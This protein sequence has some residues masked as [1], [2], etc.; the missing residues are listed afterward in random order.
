MIT[1]FLACTIKIKFF[2]ELMETKKIYIY[3]N[4]LLTKNKYKKTLLWYNNNLRKKWSWT[5]DHYRYYSYT[6][7]GSFYWTGGLRSTFFI[8]IISPWYR[9]HISIKLET[10]HVKSYQMFCRKRI[11]MLTSLKV[12]SLARTCVF[13]RLELIGKWG[14]NEILSSWNAKIKYIN[15]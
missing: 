12:S 13:Y 11:S 4:I 7:S 5:Y 14:P 3:L 9:D 10:K 8:A 15:G 6:Y 1:T 2:A